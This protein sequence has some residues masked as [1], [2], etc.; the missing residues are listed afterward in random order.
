MGKQIRGARRMIK[1]KITVLTEKGKEAIITAPKTNRGGKIIEKIAG[2]SAEQTTETEL[3]VT[4]KKLN[5][6]MGEMMK[7]QYRKVFAKRGLKENK[8]YN[9]EVL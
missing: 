9:L 1:I 5:I 8:D 6:S 3:T 7:E 2:I 4:I